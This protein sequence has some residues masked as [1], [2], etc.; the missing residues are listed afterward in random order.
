MSEPPALSH[1][2][3][4]H[5]PNLVTCSRA[6]IA[7][8][9]FVVLSFPESRSALLAGAILF[10]V[11]MAGDVLDGWLARRMGAESDLGRVLDPIIDK[12][13]VCGS[14]VYCIRVPPEIM[15]PWMVVVVLTRE[16]G[17][18]AL[19]GYIESRGVAFKAMVWG[20]LKTFLECLAVTAV[21]VTGCV[22]G[23]VAWLV[24]STRILVWLMLAVV[25]LSG[26]ERG[27][28]AHAALL[29][30][31]SYADWFV[32]TNMPF[33]TPGVRLSYGELMQQEAIW[34]G[35]PERYIFIIPGI[36][37]TTY[38]EAIAV[39]GLAQDRE[40]RSLIVVTD[41]Y[42]TRRARMAF[43]EVFR[44]S[45]ITVAVQPVNEHEYR[46]DSWWQSRD[47]LRETWTEYAK[48]VL[49]LIGYK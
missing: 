25:A 4:R 33:D 27:R 18:T 22:G 11:S 36:V 43:R 14:M 21:L 17:I 26:G 49:H 7:V 15:A 13:V 44:G 31:Q 35:V 6:V 28:A 9:F 32:V 10:A 48:L 29:F 19:R 37:E 20:K 40:W 38:D 12:V 47:G 16:F 39:R 42:H 41:P 24:L 2:L 34:Q 30:N 3:R 23:D 46:A 5:V 8:P 45:G 1:G